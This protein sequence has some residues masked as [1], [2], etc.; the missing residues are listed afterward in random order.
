MARTPQRK[1]GRSGSGQTGGGQTGG[2]QTG[3]AQT[4]GRDGGKGRNETPEAPPSGSGP[5]QQPKTSGDASRP[6][7][8][9]DRPT[10]GPGAE[11][12]PASAPAT[13]AA[14]AKPPETKPPE[15]RPAD[16]KSAVTKPPESK[17]AEPKPSEAEPAASGG[18][19]GRT[20]EARPGPGAGEPR[21][22]GGPPPGGGAPP[23]QPSGGGFGRALI[24][25]V[26]GAV[27]VL[28]LLALMPEGLR[29]NISGAP[30]PELQQRVVALEAALDEAT[31]VDPGPRLDELEGRLAELAAIEP[32][33]PPDVTPLEERLG[34]LEERVGIIAETPPPA[35]VPPE[36]LEAVALRLDALERRLAALDELPADL[37]DLPDLA[38]VIS[39]L[40]DYA[41][42]I[43]ALETAAVTPDDL[44]AVQAGLLARIEDS[45]ADAATAQD[46][47]AVE[48]RLEAALSAIET[49]LGERLQADLP[50]LAPIEQRLAA[51]ADVLPDQA[52]R[53]D[54]LAGRIDELAELTAALG[55][56]LDGL[57]GRVATADERSARAV[58]VTLAT[59]RIR[60][61][62]ALGQPFDAPLAT[63]RE[64][65]GDEEPVA[66]AAAELLPVAATG[67]ASMGELRQRFRPAA[68]EAEH[69]ALA[70]EGEGL[71]EQAADRVLRLVTVRRVEED[72][73]GI[74]A[75]AVVARAGARLEAGDL[76]GAVAE[77]ELLEGGPRAAFEDWLVDA[78]TRL[79]ADRAVARL[80]EH[81]LALLS[82]AP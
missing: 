9:P 82:A 80:E 11:P 77:I 33:A 73:D 28:V 1:A 38:P 31:E 50:D 62:L 64:L 17:P 48:A 43:E 19:A 74:G 45:L 20:A 61:A 76:A 18:A 35:T 46:L 47:A 39:R 79:A 69:R 66:E 7:Q 22:P 57:E 27:L 13:P 63:L 75:H 36:E 58:A 55:R 25:G 23:P 10:P 54:L 49:S 37:A 42:R 53:Q 4:G 8:A 32:P 29:R 5:E 41:A 60:E 40:E 24:A 52:D 30:G 6:D 15:A 65:A 12:R 70:P 26:V 34:R 56:Q 68:D 78:R 59:T 72:E 3:G 51:I 44:E 67:V 16:A 14:Q 21:G 2:G 71:L 81:A